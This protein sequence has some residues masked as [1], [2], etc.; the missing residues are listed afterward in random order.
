MK[1]IVWKNLEIR[2]PLADCKDSML[3]DSGTDIVSLEDKNQEYCLRV[4]VLGET[5]IRFKDQIYRFASDFPQELVDM[6]E[7]GEIY[8]E[9]NTAAEVLSSNW[10]SAGFFY[11]GAFIDDIIYDRNISELLEVELIE[12]LRSIAVEFINIYKEDIDAGLV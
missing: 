11:N 8:S 6:I 4:T 3:F 9:S 2:T 12:D 7:S 5:C 10:Y 1:D